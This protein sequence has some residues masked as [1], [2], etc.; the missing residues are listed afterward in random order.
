MGRA[1]RGPYA[2][3]SEYPVPY[4]TASVW[5]TGIDPIHSYYGEGP[6]IRVMGRTGTIGSSPV[7][8]QSPRDRDYQTP[9]HGGGMDAPQEITWGYPVE[10]G[11]DSFGSGAN[12]PIAEEDVGWDDAFY[13][14]DRPVWGNET[15][16]S[17]NRTSS[18]MPSW[19]S[20][21]AKFLATR[22]G[23]ARYRAWPEQP[24]KGQAQ[25]YEPVSAE[26]VNSY[27]TE[28]VSE[29]WI[30]KG[31]SFTAY[32]EPADDSQVFVQTSMRQRFGTRDNGRAVLRGTDDERSKIGSRVMAMVEKVYSEGE[33]TYDMFPYQID[34][35]E[36]P[37]RFR[38]AGVGPAGW[39]LT[40]EYGAVTPVQRVPPPDP[41][42]GVPE[43]GTDY[44]TERYAGDYGYTTEDPYYA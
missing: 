15:E 12:A 40:N 33:R 7:A 28:T 17:K 16:T 39:M 6:P 32:A 38:T 21:A 18:P 27:P 35:I 20:S 25:A 41:A 24:L 10:Y 19:G 31:T 5:G 14:D 34:Q 4:A 30:N 8:T 3:P 9:G 26:A 22:M 42:M 29:G 11:P 37:F 2:R 23:A 44:V 13:V 36:R 43:V 1:Y